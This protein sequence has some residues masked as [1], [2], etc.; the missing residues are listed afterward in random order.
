MQL[1]DKTAKYLLLLDME[2]SI[3]QFNSKLLTRL[4]AS[5]QI[6]IVVEEALTKVFS[7]VKKI[8]WFIV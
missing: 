7:L 4:R 5:F 2:R 8:R 1:S 6:F 3:I